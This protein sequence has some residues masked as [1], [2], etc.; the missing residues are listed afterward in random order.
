MF[1]FMTPS[2][3]TK[4]SDLREAERSIFIIATNYEDH[5]DRAIKRKGRVDELLLWLPM[6]L[7]ARTEQFKKFVDHAFNDSTAKSDGLPEWTPETES[8]LKE[9]AKRTS[10]LTY[11]ELETCFKQ[12]E[13]RPTSSNRQTFRQDYVEQLAKLHEDRIPKPDLSLE[14]YENRTK[15][16]P[17]KS[18]E[19]YVQRPY[20]E[21]ASLLILKGESGNV[22][23]EESFLA[24]VNRWCNDS[25]DDYQR[26]WQRIKRRAKEYGLES[27]VSKAERSIRKS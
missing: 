16:A 7:K 15:S 6:D 4:I 21:Y 5:I 25:P 11:P 19:E 26:K 17:E 14:A 24:L 13:K 3:L 22:E 12:V 27:W 9:F 18:E 2:M 8:A 10:L 23:G 1:Q 20:E